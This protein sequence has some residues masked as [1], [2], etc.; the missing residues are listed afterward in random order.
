VIVTSFLAMA[1]SRVT[2]GAGCQSKLPAW[3][4]VTA[5]TKVPV[6]TMVPSTIA[7]GAPSGT[8]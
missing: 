8:L 2:G 4:A 5:H 3:V 6:N 7:H 1:I